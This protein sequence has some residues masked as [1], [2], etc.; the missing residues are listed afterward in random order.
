MF[1]TSIYFLIKNLNYISIIPLK[2]CVRS[3]KKRASPVPKAFGMCVEA[4]FCL[5]PP[6][7]IVSFSSKE[8]ES[9][10]KEINYP[11]ANMVAF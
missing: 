10:K 2:M 4:F 9:R 8:K 5:V 3:A 7:G 11:L 1:Y 6:C